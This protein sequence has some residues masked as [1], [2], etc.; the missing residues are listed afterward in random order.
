MMDAHLAALAIEHRAVLAASDCDFAHFPG[1]R[2]V[3]SA[4]SSL[5]GVSRVLRV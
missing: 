2:R 4:V 3:E 1:L 5:D